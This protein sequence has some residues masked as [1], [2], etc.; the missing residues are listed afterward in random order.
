MVDD[1]PYNLGLWDT[2]GI[3]LMKFIICLFIGIFIQR[4]IISYLSTGQEEYDRL[5]ALCYPQTDVFLMCFSL[6]SPSSF[7][8]IKIRV[9]SEITCL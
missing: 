1:T 5:R 3:F 4:F 6:I 8:N 7:E 2:A 9:T